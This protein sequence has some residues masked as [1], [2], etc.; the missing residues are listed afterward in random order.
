MAP[1]LPPP[2]ERKGPGGEDNKQCAY[3]DQASGCVGHD[4]NGDNIDCDKNV[5]QHPDPPIE[6]GIFEQEGEIWDEVWFESQSDSVNTDNMG[7]SDD[8]VIDCHAIN[9]KTASERLH[10][11]PD[12]TPAAKQN[13]HLKV[14]DI[15]RRTAVYNV[16]GP[17]IPLNTCN[18]IDAWKSIATGHK[19][20]SW[21]V[22]C[23]EF[24]FPLQYSGPPIYSVFKANH[25]SG[26]RFHKEVS[27]Y[28][29]KEL[30]L[31]ALA[32][33]FH[34]PPFAPWCNVAP[35]MTRPKSN[36]VDRRVIVDLSYPV[37]SGP[38]SHI[39]K[40]FI[41][42]AH[43]SHTL[44]SVQ[45]A[46]N[47]I[48]SYDFNVLLATIDVA[49]AYRN[50]A[51]DPLD[52]PL[53]CICH[54]DV[55]YVDLCM[56]FGSR[57]SSVYMQKMANYIGRALLARGIHA[58][59]YLD[60]A[61]I[62]C[63]RDSLPT[64]IFNTVLQVIRYIGL[65]IAWD[66]VIAPCRALKFLGVI[67]D[68][69]AR[70]IRIPAQ[71]I[72][73]FVQLAHRTR[74]KKTITKRELQSIIGHVNFI[75]KAVPP[76]RLFINRMLQALRDA[77]QDL[78][79]VDY[80]LRA[81]LSWFIKFLPKYNGRSLI[82]RKTPT[83]CIEADSSLVAGGAFMGSRCYSFQYSTWIAN[84]LNIAQLEAYNCLVAARV[85]LDDCTDA[86]VEVKCDNAAAISSLTTGRGRDA[87]LMRICRAFWY[88]AASKNIVFVFTHVPGI[89]MQIAD[90][91]S[92]KPLSLSQ[93]K[94][95]D[96]LARNYSLSYCDVPQKCRD[97]KKYF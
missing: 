42:G 62:V 67:I 40:N 49:R 10:S 78:I 46:V 36:N 43:V 39:V 94:K 18:R 27:E 60:D 51:V 81:D 69:E 22:E 56:P 50:F 77:N 54:D 13:D 1:C 64:E 19:D 38:N 17:R 34:V 47:I 29:T 70:E 80:H 41:F 15:C 7:P 76:A 44:P 72:D 63:P 35:I 25:P 14:Y 74:A 65:P 68:V 73:Q 61:I 52:W 45:D 12:L 82:V 48:L 83:M 23:I 21:L 32:G 24:G 85:F 88:L 89:C 16:F 84:N 33:P 4:K 79:V 3:N 37:D 92:R 96:D 11:W 57:I 53:N 55:F 87:H 8:V 71:K 90:A 9:E 93:S 20:D 6:V 95:A 66:K 2:A 5:G 91:L 75:G 97:F 31:G 26:I 28:I 86:C 30:S 59:L 58:V